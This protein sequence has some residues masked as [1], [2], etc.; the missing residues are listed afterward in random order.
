MPPTSNILINRNLLKHLRAYG[1]TRG[2]LFT[3]IK[4][5]SLD[6][7]PLNA[8]NYAHQFVYTGSRGMCL[9]IEFNS[10]SDRLSEAEK[11]E[12]KI[13]VIEVGDVEG[14]V[15]EGFEDSFFDLGGKAGGW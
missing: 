12:F 11:E 13:E 2:K 4:R 6:T 10:L 9:D 15:F 1:L 7:Y 14:R 5:L 8:L 3:H